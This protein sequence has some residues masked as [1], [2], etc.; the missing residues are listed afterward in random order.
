MNHTQNTH[1][2]CLMHLYP[3]GLYLTQ[4]KDCN[5]V[6]SKLILILDDLLWVLTDSQ[7]KAMVQYAKSLS[8]A[9]EK[10]AQ[11]RK[12][13]ATEDQV[14]TSPTHRTSNTVT[15]WL[16][17]F[18]PYFPVTF[19]VFAPCM[20]WLPPLWISHEVIP[21]PL[22]PD[23]I[24]HRLHWLHSTFT[25]KSFTDCLLL[26]NVCSIVWKD[27]C[28]KITVLHCPS[29]AWAWLFLLKICT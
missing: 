18:P 14:H 13:M 16:F 29:V 27:I 22:C 8:E 28:W 19:L 25:S 5:V 20:P 3:N 21:A 17:S 10:S 6:A 12:S 15:Q 7:L 11:Q 1:T 26:L 2:Y 4:I 23:A 9:M 24:W